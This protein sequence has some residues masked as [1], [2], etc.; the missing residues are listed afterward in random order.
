[1]QRLT[2]HDGVGTVPAAAADRLRERRAQQAG[3][4]CGTVQVAG[5]LAGVFPGIDMGQDLAFGEGLHGLSQRIALGCGPYGHGSS[6][7]GMSM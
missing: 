7:S 3:G 4:R 1:M 2:D 6:A 5:Q